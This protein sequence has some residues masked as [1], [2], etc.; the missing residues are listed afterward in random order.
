MAFGFNPAPMKRRIATLK[1]ILDEKNVGKG[2]IM[3]VLAALE[4][5]PVRPWRIRIER[6]LH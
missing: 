3:T 5:I 1:K 6:D 2:L 4:G